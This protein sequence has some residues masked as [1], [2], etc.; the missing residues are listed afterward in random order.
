MDGLTLWGY[1]EIETIETCRLGWAGAVIGSP[2]RCEDIGSW[3]RRRR[4]G[5]SFTPLRG[6]RLKPGAGLRGG[7][8]GCCAHVRSLAR[9]GADGQGAAGSFT[10]TMGTM[11]LSSTADGRLRRQREGRADGQRGM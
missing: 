1:M 4:G 7:F 9:F 10:H 2:D 5:V 11:R 6:R 8:G 3:A